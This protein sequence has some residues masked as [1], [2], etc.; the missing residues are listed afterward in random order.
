MRFEWQKRQDLYLMDFG[1][2]SASPLLRGVPVL[3]NVQINKSILNHLPG[4][5]FFYT[6]NPRISYPNFKQ[7]GVEVKLLYYTDDEETPIS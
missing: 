2:S 7:L 5:L 6:E 3:V 4:S 1:Y